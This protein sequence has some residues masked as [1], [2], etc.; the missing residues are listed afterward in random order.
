M[1]R[2]VHFAA[3]GHEQTARGAR[4]LPSGSVCQTGAERRRHPQVMTV[5]DRSSVEAVAPPPE[6]IVKEYTLPAPSAC[7]MTALGGPG[8]SGGA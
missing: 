8:I 7:M 6:Y 3:A 4:N 1:P 2:H 5:V